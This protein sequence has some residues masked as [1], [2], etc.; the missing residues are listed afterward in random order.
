MRNR[1]AVISVTSAV[2][3]VGAAV[4]IQ[5]RRPRGEVKRA[6][7]EEVKGTGKCVECHR[8]QTAGIVR[9]WQDSRH[10]QAGITCFDCHKPR[11]QAHQLEHKGFQI[12]RF[13]TS[14]T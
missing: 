12:T 4:F 6:T 7:A 8:E 9:Q 1:V 2:V 14:G 11:D 3:A 10:A 5:S 13:V